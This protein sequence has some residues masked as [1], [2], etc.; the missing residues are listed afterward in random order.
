MRCDESKTK[1]MSD[2]GAM[3]CGTRQLLDK[4]L[5]LK[6]KWLI[7]TGA[8]EHL[9]SRRDWF[10]E[11]QPISPVVIRTANKQTMT[12]IGKGTIQ[13]SARSKKSGGETSLTLQNVLYVPRCT[14]SLL[15]VTKLL[16]I[17]NRI[18]CTTETVLLQ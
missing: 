15:S 17:G 9:T 18:Q 3:P 12:A 10:I 11:Y 14:N 8:S 2:V 4:T 6:D 5:T 13:L 1:Q 16:G 7:D